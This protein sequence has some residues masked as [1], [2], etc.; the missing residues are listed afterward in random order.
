[1]PT[2]ASGRARPVSGSALLRFAASTFTIASTLL[3][4]AP[5][6]AAA[7]TSGGVTGSV[8]TID[9]QPIPEA[10]VT[11]YGNGADRV[12]RTDSRG[13][14]ALDGMPG[15]T[16]SIRLVA[17][18]YDP[19]AGN[20]LDVR[21]PQPT[22]V[23]LEMIRSSTSLITIGRVANQTGTALSTSAVPSQDIGALAASAR[24][25][26]S[27]G[28]M[29]TRDAISAT[30][31]HPTGGNPAAP[32]VVALRG[33]DP[34]ETLVDIDGHSI[35]SGGT[36]SFDLSLLDP[37]ALSS[38]QLVYGI[39][40]ASLVGPNTIGGAINVRTLEPT[41]RPHGLLRM[42]V[43]SFNSFGETVQATGTESRLAYAFSLHRR[44]TEGEQ[45]GERIAA[46]DGSTPTVGS[47]VDGSTALGKIRYTFGRGD[48]FLGLT[49]RDQSQFRDLSAALSSI[50]EPAANDAAPVFN[51]FA[52]SSL[53][54]HNAGYGVDLQLPLGR[55]AEDAFTRTSLL[56]RHLTS[57]AD[58]SVFGSA[59]GS[60]LYLYNDRDRLTDDSL[61]MTRYLSKGV[62]SLKVAARN[63]R[64]DTEQVLG[65]TVEQ[66][67]GFRHRPLGALTAGTSAHGVRAL[68]DVL[69]TN[70]GAGEL[71]SL[72]GLGQTQRSAVLK[73]A[74]DP[75][76]KL[77]Y[78]L[79][80]YYSDF[81]SFGTSLDPRIGF[82]WTPSARS[83]MRLSAGSTFQSPQL[84]ELYVPAELPPP[85]ANGYINIGNPQLKADHATEY[86]VGYEHVFGAAR[87]TRTSVD[88]YG[89]NLRTPAQRFIPAVKCL[90]ATG[91]A[92]DPEDCESFPIN[93]GG[94]VYQGVELRLEHRIAR[95]MSV[96]AAYSINSSYA[97]S[98]AP[99]FS[100]GTIV[101]GEQ[102]AGSPLHKGVLSI[103]N[104]TPAGL[105][106]Q[107]AVSYEDGYNEL[108]RAAYATLEAGLTWHLTPVYDIGVFGTNL[109]NVY[110]D[111]FTQLGRGVPYGGID[112]PIAT[113]AYALAARK[114]TL[115]FS[116]RY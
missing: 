87:Q 1:M 7:Q 111:K 37:A 60:S 22:N 43:G 48:A 99:Q 78:T 10:I 36:G 5:S 91:P 32:V 51:S 80:A 31:V 28:E 34:T 93:A 69:D 19:L 89:T 6:A 108:N 57:I 20:T 84:P 75:T 76:A 23:E 35:N 105:A 94:A 29:L 18:G 46:A 83:A 107:A 45:R 13:Q 101:P 47:A 77:H 50:L 67:Q 106:Y 82:V 21:P 14:F 98:V 39:S 16:Y 72:S 41:A 79:A 104:D 52:S 63:E 97:T 61:E 15:G 95:T 55:P 74:F 70:A 113:D 17:H 38:V 66:D 81:T 100:N 49:I 65:G 103:E 112:E 44:T 114:I 102:F 40:P 27:V 88:F 3:N 116:R 59:G 110:A 2:L 11:L 58:Q 109:T 26:S 90:G 62:L 73:Y 8:T 64:L 68:G 9:G 24:G 85:D 33:P 12:G 42:S 86:D 30:I 4:G 25:T 96:R 71:V 92:V 115:V 56:F 53:R 54:A